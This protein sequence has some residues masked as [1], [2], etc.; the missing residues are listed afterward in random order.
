MWFTFCL[1]SSPLFE[2]PEYYGIKDTGWKTEVTLIKIHTKKLIRVGHSSFRCRNKMQLSADQEY[3][4]NI[5]VDGNR[6]C[7][8]KKPSHLLQCGT[9]IAPADTDFQ[10]KKLYRRGD[11][12]P[13]TW[14]WENKT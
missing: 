12:I 4:N 9:I 8:K 13:R 3:R 7:Y 1:S 2:W 5:N 6:P 14:C 10:R 11:V